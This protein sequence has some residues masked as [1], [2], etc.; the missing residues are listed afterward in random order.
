MS[1]LETPGETLRAEDSL[2]DDLA[3][4]CRISYLQGLVRGTGGNMSVRIDDDVYITATGCRLGDVYPG[5]L[6]KVSLD[7][8]KV[9]NGKPSKELNLHLGVYRS[10]KDVLAIAH[11]HPV[12]S[13]AAS[14]LN[15]EGVEIMPAYT[16][17]YA[18]KIASIGMVPLLK[19][20][21]EEL[22]RAVSDAAASY[23]V[24]LMKN[25]GIISVAKDIKAALS[26]VE[27]AEQNAALHIILRGKGGIL[28]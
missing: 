3:G 22:A 18:A 4:C 17:A 10:R 5:T 6:V 2:L 25:H 11:L 12:N 21:S 13:I 23:N 27:E 19:P 14:I 1:S 28:F 8:S 15:R 20:G 16:P 7:G 9:M 26:L 24:I